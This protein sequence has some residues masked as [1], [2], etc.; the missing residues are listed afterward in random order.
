MATVKRLLVWGAV[1]AL[2]GVVAATSI[3]PSLVGWYN[4]PGQ[5]VAMCDCKELARTTAATI[6]QAQLAGLASG[7]I[8][9]LILGTV[10]TIRARRAAAE[11]VA[12]A[13]AAAPVAP[14]AAAPTSETPPAAP[15]PPA[16]G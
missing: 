2:L 15:P 7:F 16:A 11:A 14:A 1:F 13:A 5:S 6:V 12:A 3:T 9:G 4:T 8:L 10:V